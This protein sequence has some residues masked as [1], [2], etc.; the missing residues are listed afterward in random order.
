MLTLHFF[1]CSSDTG[2]LTA[3]CHVK[4]YRLVGAHVSTKHTIR[5]AYRSCEMTGCP[6]L[7]IRPP[8]S[9]LSWIEFGHERGLDKDSI[10]V[11]R[12]A[13]LDPC[14]GVGRN[15]PRKPFHLSLTS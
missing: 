6:R 1:A 15:R 12:P 3:G 13:V 2:K 10:L 8:T 11:W 9:A 5:K 4:Y 7:G 14:L